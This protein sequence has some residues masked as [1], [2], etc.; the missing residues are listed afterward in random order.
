LRATIDGASG[1]VNVPPS[2][3]L[4][5]IKTSTVPGAISGTT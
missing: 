1:A 5:M 2:A 4:P 3:D